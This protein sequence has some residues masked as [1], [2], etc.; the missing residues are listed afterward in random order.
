V[1]HKAKATC[2]NGHTFEWG[3]C[4]GQVKKLFGGTKEC[5]MKRFEQIYS[6]GRA[7]ATVSFD[8]DRWNAVRCMS[9]GTVFTSTR[10][11]TCGVEVPVSSFEKK[12]FYAKL[13]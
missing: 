7:P 11:A 1:N 3:A 9:C 2:S 13:S 6:D 12:G 5:G 10:C 4:K 8:G